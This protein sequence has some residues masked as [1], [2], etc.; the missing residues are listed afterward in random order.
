MVGEDIIYLK[1][2]PKEWK[3]QS[4]SI[5]YKTFWLYL[6]LGVPTL[7][8]AGII[9]RTRT[10][11]ALEK[12]VVRARRQQAPKVA[13][14]NIQRLEQAIRKKDESAFYEAAWDT[15]AD[16]FGHRLN[17]APG[18]ITL[19]TVLDRI[20]QEKERLETLFN[21]IEQRRY[22]VRVSADEATTEMK[23]ILRQLT[24]LLKTCERIK[25]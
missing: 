16:Y 21:T 14:K 25:L 4:D 6:V 5:W 13:R 3:T 15:L 2:A 12:D 1:P 10:K 24:Q 9:L 11:T 20:P 23:Q 22:G 7:I 19:P 17:L 8:L 18:E